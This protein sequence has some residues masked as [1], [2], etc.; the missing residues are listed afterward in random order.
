MAKYIGG[1]MGRPKYTGPKEKPPPT[2]K[3]VGKPPRGKRGR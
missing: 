2:R 1:K 3:I